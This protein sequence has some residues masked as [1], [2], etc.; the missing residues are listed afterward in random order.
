[1]LFVG[2]SACRHRII[3]LRFTQG[4]LLS[5]SSIFNVFASTIF[6]IIRVQFRFWLHVK[7]FF[8]YIHLLLINRR[9]GSVQNGS[10][11]LDS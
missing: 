10:L 2:V 6:L 7:G 4:L 5:S 3:V 1:M 11:L 8:A 9:F